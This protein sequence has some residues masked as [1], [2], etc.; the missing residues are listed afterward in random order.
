MCQH[1]AWATRRFGPDGHKIM[2][3]TTGE[4]GEDPG[5]AKHD[6]PQRR[7]NIQL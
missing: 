4:R 7:P 1:A 6:S 5:S 3:A 2:R